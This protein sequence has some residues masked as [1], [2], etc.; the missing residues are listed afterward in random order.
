MKDLCCISEKSEYFPVQIHVESDL[1]IYEDQIKG[2]W[3]GFTVRK[4]VDI[5]ASVYIGNLTTNKAKWKKVLYWIAKHTM[6]K[7][8]QFINAWRI[9]LQ[10]AWKKTTNA[11]SLT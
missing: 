11:R 10:K 6:Q 2:T 3:S 7:K 9:R 8:Y 4:C 5:T 1:H